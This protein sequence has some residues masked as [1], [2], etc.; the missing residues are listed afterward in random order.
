MAQLADNI[1][2]V[3]SQSL[4]NKTTAI[5]ATHYNITELAKLVEDLQRQVSK[6]LTKNKATF[7]KC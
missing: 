4:R 6:L 5:S 3:R 2:N 1:F 7:E